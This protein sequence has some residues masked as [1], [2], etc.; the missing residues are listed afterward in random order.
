MA[1][2]DPVTQAD[3]RIRDLET[4]VTGL[5]EQLATANSHQRLGSVLAHAR[6]ACTDCQQDLDQHNQRVIKAA[7]EGL[8]V[9]SARELALAKGALPQSLNFQ[10]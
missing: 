8:D 3:L 7:F 4:Q 10:V 1:A 2:N 9:V 5:T 6:E